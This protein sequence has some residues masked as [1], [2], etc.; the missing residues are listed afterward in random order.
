MAC[1]IAVAYLF[2]LARR[3][4]LRLFPSRERVELEFAP[5][6]RRAAPTAGLA[7]PAATTELRQA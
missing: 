3:G 2:S 6:A 1:C 4:F 5:T 7:S